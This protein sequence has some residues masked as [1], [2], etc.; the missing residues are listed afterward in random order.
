MRRLALV[1]SALVACGSPRGGDE[2]AERAAQAFASAEAVLLDFDFAGKVVTA[3]PAG[4]VRS[5][6]VAQLMYS[7]GQLNSDR[8]IGRFERLS[9]HEVASK[10]TA[11]GKIEIS[12]RAK[13]PVA[14][15]NAAT[16]T[17]Y[18]FLLPARV[19]ENDAVTF[20]TKYGKTC[21]DPSGGDVDAARMF[22]FYR[23]R[24]TGCVIE[25]ADVEKL[26]A[27]VTPSSDTTT[28][29]YP[30][31]DR[32][33]ED[34]ALDVVAIFSRDKETA[35]VADEGAAAH[36]ELRK[37]ARDY[38]AWLQ[39]DATRRTEGSEELGAVLPDGRRITVRSRLVSPR[40]EADGAAF[41]A[42]FDAVTPSADF[43]LYNGHA[44]L[45]E[46]VRALAKKGTFVPRKYVVWAVNGC[47]T[48]AYLD[49]TL[50]DR[51]ARV[52]PDDPA[53]TRYM[54]R[55][56]NVLAGYFRTTPAFSMSFVDAAVRATGANAKPMTYEQIFATIDPEQVVVVTG[57]EDNTFRP[58]EGTA[59]AAVV[60]TPDDAQEPAP[61]P[62][63]P[64]SSGC[65]AAPVGA[66]EAA[67]AWLLLAALAVI[68]ERRRRS[69]H[70]AA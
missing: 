50:A 11:D 38:L 24:A 21:V 25:D 39:P 1:L 2:R 57:E 55:V 3:S 12:Y 56:S 27:L 36:A 63:P 34:G 47:D 66:A 64:A 8:A 13:L 19:T 26:D 46:N 42:W 60:A 58:K 43:I 52:N 59:P 17:Q 40:I 70:R 7:I 15:A 30:E 45:G 49:H 67:P 18:T 62:L 37:V 29:A 4:D 5:V 61:E 68:S 31:Y 48:F 6:I 51:R 41:D 23:P 22:L 14:W 16:P 10:P 9:L 33:W 54:D 65:R 35:D 44:A 28:G 32:I 20:A 53:G 69:R